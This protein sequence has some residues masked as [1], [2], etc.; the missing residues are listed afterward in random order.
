MDTRYFGAISYSDCR[1]HAFLFHPSLLCLFAQ[2]R[3]QC[4][5][6]ERIKSCALKYDCHHEAHNSI[7]FK[8]V[9]VG[10][11]ILKRVTQMLMQ[12]ERFVS[13]LL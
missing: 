9:S 13:T 6:Q 8:D 11:C 4:S 2:L 10:Q 1:H 5:P 12:I 3:H 7:N